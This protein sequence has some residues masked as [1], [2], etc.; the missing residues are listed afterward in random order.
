MATD[1]GIA[2]VF[3]DHVAAEFVDMDL[4]ATMATMTDDPYVNHVPVMT[5]G[6]GF[7]GVR[8]FYG[9]HFIGKW[10]DDVEIQPVSRTVGESQVVDE[11][12]LSFTHDIEMPQLLPGIAPTGRPVRLAF[13]VVVGFADGK[14]AHEHIYWDQASLL[15]QVGLLDQAALPVTGAEQAANVLDPRANPLNELIRR[16]A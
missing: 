13:C 3:D 12:V 11:L 6:V 5:G 9:D 16:S 15:V 2:G 14:V 1:R 4:E 10:P 8:T 7:E